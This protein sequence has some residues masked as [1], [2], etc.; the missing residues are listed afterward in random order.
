MPQ[1][2]TQRAALLVKLHDAES[3]EH[4]LSQDVYAIGR[5]ADNDLAID[6]PAVSA[7]HARI[8]KIHA[9]YFIEDLQS[10]NGTLVNAKRIDRH[11]LHDA[12]VIMI[13]RHRLIF[14]DGSISPGTGA[15]APEDLDHTMVLTGHA[16]RRDREV[17]PANVRVLSGKTD[18]REY[19]LLRQISLVGSAADAVVKLTGWFAPSR[20]ALIT[21][22]GQ[23][24]FV[25]K[26]RGGKPLSVNGHPVE[27]EQE[28]KDKDCIEVAGTTLLFR[29]G[30]GGGA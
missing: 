3:R 27:K 17:S 24:Y 30:P 12:D 25:S 11:Q 19:L 29:T 26:I 20:A 16:A 14:R 5:K 7:H 15:R 2:T 13:G 28:L 8:I 1:T 18:Q 23:T 9:V 10:T 22:R 6:D 21:R 4:D